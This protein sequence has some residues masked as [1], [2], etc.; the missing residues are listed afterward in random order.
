M[1]T[2]PDKILDFAPSSSSSFGI[3]T[4]VHL[5]APS[6]RRHCKAFANSNAYYHQRGMMTVDSL[7]MGRAL[8]T[9]CK[10][11]QRPF[12]NALT[13]RHRSLPALSTRKQSTYRPQVS[14]CQLCSHGNNQQR[15]HSTRS[16]VPDESEQ[17]QCKV[18]QNTSSLGTIV[19]NAA[20]A[21]AIAA[22]ILAAVRRI[23]L[24][25][26]RPCIGVL[27]PGN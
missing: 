22:L 5:L 19:R 23:L 18:E 12:P 8:L 15:R 3:Q 4:A 17:K 25:L 14:R 27:L 10:Q 24:S 26:L 21:T 7:S 2:C 9:P 20:K 13:F 16:A 1:Q 11:L 6:A